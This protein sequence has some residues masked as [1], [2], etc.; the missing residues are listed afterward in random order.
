MLWLVAR[1]ARHEG[2]S[3]AVIA[4]IAGGPRVAL[5]PRVDRRQRRVMGA[6]R[7]AKKNRPENPA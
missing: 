2:P 3:V 1:M 5:G 6:R 7:A 4:W